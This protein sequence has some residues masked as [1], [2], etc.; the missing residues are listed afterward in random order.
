M[1]YGAVVVTFNRQQLLI[2]SI[3]AL[4]QQTVPPTK[5]IIIDNHSTDDTRDALQANGILANPRDRKSVV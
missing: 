4:M 2:E 1:Q 5:I 3:T